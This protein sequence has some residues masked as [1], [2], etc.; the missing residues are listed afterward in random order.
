MKIISK[1]F[2]LLPEKIAYL[3]GDI[4]GQLTWVFVPQKRKN[5][6]LNNAIH[7]LNISKQ[8]AKKIVKNSWTRFGPMII[9]VLRFPIM[10]D[11]MNDYINLLGQE[12]L[13]AALKLGRGGII[14]AAHSDNWELLGGALAQNGYKLVGVS[15]KQSN[16]GAD[17]FM[18][19]Y[20]AMVGMYIMY[21][22]DVRGMFKMI[23]KG[24]LI[25]LIMDQDAAEDGI[26]MPFLGRDASCAHGA[27]TIA[28]RTEAPIIPI[29]IAKGPGRTHNI[30]ID[31]AVFV[32]KTADKHEDIRKAT[33]LLT[34]KIEEHI[35]KYPNEW[36][37]LHNRWKS[38]N[39]N[40]TT[41][42]HLK[43]K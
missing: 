18:N 13:D 11:N 42:N 20:R 38:I 40:Q 21:K 16:R 32:E 6:A 19:E 7:G 33:M 22:Y 17:R 35:K 25:G 27:A 10:R 41:K 26:V 24:Y 37:W 23:A 36:F 1:I 12:N 8:E 5:M 43:R 14:A 15:Q 31:K 2:C 9:E 39:Q 34:Q 30:I 3:I 29:F 4:I 28:R